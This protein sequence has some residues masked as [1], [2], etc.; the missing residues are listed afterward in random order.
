[1][2]FIIDPFSWAA[3]IALA[4][5]VVMMIVSYALAPKPKKQKPDATKDLENPTAES[6][7]PIP[8]VFGSITVKSG[9]VLWY[10]EKGK[11]DYQVRA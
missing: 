1:M 8:V 5:S 2:V 10:G 3:L 11:H 7:R 6:G 9:N 4:I